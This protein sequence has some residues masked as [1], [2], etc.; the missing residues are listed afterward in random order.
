MQY[1]YQPTDKEINSSCY[2]HKEKKDCRVVWYP[3]PKKENGKQVFNADGKKEFI[4]IVM[5]KTHKV[6]LCYKID[7][8]DQDPHHCFWELGGHFDQLSQGSIQP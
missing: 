5:C 6:R 3:L 7:F 4:N 1:P 8:E 2:H